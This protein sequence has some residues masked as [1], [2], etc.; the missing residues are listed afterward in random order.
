MGT[1]LYVSTQILHFP[2]VSLF[3]R[4]LSL[5]SFGNYWGNSYTTFAVLDIMFRFT[6]DKSDLY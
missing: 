6:S 2:D 5:K 1:R 3:P 4:I